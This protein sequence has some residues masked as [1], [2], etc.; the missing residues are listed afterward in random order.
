MEN[1]DPKEVW[2]Y[3]EEITKIPRCSGEEE[4]VREFVRSVAEEKGYEID[5]D[6][7]GNILV[8]K[9]GT[10]K[11]APPLVIQSHLDMVCEKTSESDHDFSEDPITMRKENGW[12]T[13]DGTTLGADNGIGVAISLAMM[14][15]DQLTH[16]PLEFLFTVGEEIGLIGAKEIEP[17]FFYGRTLINL[18]SEQFGTFT[19]GCAGS[20]DSFI[21][22]PL[23][24]EETD[25]KDFYEIRIH[26][27]KG[28]HS[29]LD[30]HKGRG[31]ANKIL[32]RIIFEV[33][34]RILEKSSICLNHIEGGNKK[35]TI[36][37][38]SRAILKF[39]NEPQQVIKHMRDVF[40]EVKKEYL[41]V[42]EEMKLEI[43]P[44][45]LNKGKL[46]ENGDSK[47]IIDLIL[48]LPHGV[49]S[50]NQE[51][52]GLVK[53]STNLATLSTDDDE[54]KITMMTRS[55]SKPEILAIRDRIRIIAESLGGYVEESVAYPG[56][57]VD[58]DSEI[59]K[60]SK[61]VYKKIFGEEP[62]IGAMHAGLETR[63]ISVKFE[64]M[65]MISFGPTLK[66]PHTTS[67]KVE[68][69]S[70]EKL[71]RLVTSICEEHARKM[72]A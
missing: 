36:P 46:I 28:G 11:N 21:K 26:G 55:S 31:N 61:E 3:F 69:K 8:K 68:I 45:D 1:L 4:K 53:T 25:A 10:I 6:D 32:A 70:V 34:D 39:E 44:F 14:T 27:L 66:D 17:G 38:Q 19:I 18:D 42:D 51:V 16:G 22:L 50:M 2:N 64:G 57:E 9:P 72:G 67:E 24:Y 48:A 58:T 43:E 35:N 37:M 7:V 23:K 20:G 52:P 5:I 56:W 49:L 29:G 41:A 60:I 33:Y 59:L 71:W 63:V 62:N 40:S 13:A 54:L 47:K 65:D 30:I 12:I 15:D